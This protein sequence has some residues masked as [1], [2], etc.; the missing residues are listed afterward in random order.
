MVLCLDGIHEKFDK[1]VRLK[2]KQSRTL[3]INQP[4]LQKSRLMK[5]YQIKNWPESL[6]LPNSV[7][8]QLLRIGSTR[9]ILPLI[10]MKPERAFVSYML[11]IL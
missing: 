6:E 8:R 11:S 5:R 1:Y 3:A 9:K 7:W 4:H 10:C 2:F